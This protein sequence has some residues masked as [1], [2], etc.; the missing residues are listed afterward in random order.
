MDNEQK[1]EEI[2]I[3]L[4]KLSNINAVKGSNP[5]IDTFINNNTEKP[6]EQKVS[7]LLEEGYKIEHFEK[8][9]RKF[10]FVPASRVKLPSNGLPYQSCDD[11]DVREGY[12]Y[13]YSITMKEEEILSTPKYINEGVATIMT[14]NNCIKSNI[15][16]MDLVV[17]DFYFLLMYLRQISISDEFAF[18]IECPHCGNK[19]RYNIKISEQTF[20][21]LDKDNFK[22]PVRVDLP[23]TDYTVL[24]GLPRIRTIRE[25]TWLLGKNKNIGIAEFVTTRTIAI[26]TPDGEEVPKEDWI[27]FYNNLPHKDYEVL[28]DLAK[29]DNGMTHI[30]KNTKCPNCGKEIEG[31]SVNLNVDA[32]FRYDTGEPESNQE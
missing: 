16:A 30:V 28:L 2:K 31:S 25:M 10:E 24:L 4:N 5:A 7:E 8:Y 3:D 1:K 18:S 17:S 23:T 13:I 11:K 19:F 21:E 6:K 27:I 9:P 26:I 20:D 22:E 29:F 15:D 14:L 32:L 12:I